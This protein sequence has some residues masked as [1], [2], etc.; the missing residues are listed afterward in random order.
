MKKFLALLLSVLVVFGLL[1][2]CGGDPSNDKKGGDGVTVTIGIPTNALVM[3]YYDNGLTKW[4]EEETGYTIEFVKFAAGSGDYGTQ[5]STMTAAQMELPDLLLGFKLGDAVYRQYGEDGYFLDLK[6]YFADKEG[7]SKV[8]W[9][10]FEQLDPSFQNAILRRITNEDGSMYVFPSIQTSLVDTQKFT[11]WIN[12]KWLD[13]VGMEKPTDMEELYN[14]LV[15][16]RDKDPNGNGVADEIPLMGATNL[17]G[18][19]V[20]WILNMFCY[21]NE[22][23]WFNVDDNGNLY[24]PEMTD[25]YRQALIFANKLVSEGLLSNMSLTMSQASL[26]SLVTPA[27][28]GQVQ[29]I[30]IVV[31]H[32]TMGFTQEHEGLLNYEA[33]PLWGNA[34]YAENSNIRNNFITTDSKNPD[35]AWEVLMALSSQEGSLRM[36]YGELGTDWDWADEGEQSFLGIPAQYKLNRD[37]WSTQ[38]K[39]NWRTISATILINAEQEGAQ[40]TDELTEVTKH[41]YQMFADM[42]ASYLKQVEEHNPADANICPPLFYTQ[43]EV[44]A[45][46]QLRSDCTNFITK[47]RSEFVIGSQGADPSN[48]DQWNKYLETLK[49]LKVE[50]WQQLAQTAYNRDY[51]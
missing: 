45:T 17:C 33:L 20:G 30:G 3:D 48:D 27:E 7:K 50:T 18:D 15:A 42:R 44:D 28:A 37:V 24:L 13:A 32:P 4:L 6:D 10:R 34:V 23:N 47:S 5:L 25:E 19:V 14:V 2:G 43:D 46:E 16:F 1:A 29:Q 22:T 31:C 9:E 35:A 38:G 39:E 8:W 40:I 11:P 21:V 12:V 41:K 26:K 49:S 36:R 51:K